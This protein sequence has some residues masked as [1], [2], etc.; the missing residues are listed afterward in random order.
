MSQRKSDDGGAVVEWRPHLADEGCAE[1]HTR[2]TLSPSHVFMTDTGNHTARR[3]PRAPQTG[4][5]VAA[6][7][8]SVP[9]SAVMSPGSDDGA[10]PPCPRSPS[11]PRYA[12][13][14]G[15]SYMSRSRHWGPN[16][17]RLPPTPPATSFLRRVLRR[18]A[19]ST[20]PGRFL[21]GK[22]LLCLPTHRGQ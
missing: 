14:G 10:Q 22:L 8:T 3:C 18:L 7:D 12:A 2:L 13:L 15:D 6:P 16:D 5:P 4:P 20:L 1:R 21:A 17:S 11:P 19:W 9:R